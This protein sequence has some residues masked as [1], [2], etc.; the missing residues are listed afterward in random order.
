MSLEGLAL[1]L[2]DHG[3]LAAA[4]SLLERALHVRER[5]QGSAHHHTATSL[6]NLAV[7]LRDQGELDSARPDSKRA[8]ARE[9]VLGPDHPDTIATRRALAELAGGG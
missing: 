5:A 9:R 2:Q 4:R 8:L 3:E 1:L 6:H 7:V